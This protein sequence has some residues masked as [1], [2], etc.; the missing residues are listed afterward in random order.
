MLSHFFRLIIARFVNFRFHSVALVLESVMF[1][2]FVVLVLHDQLQS[3]SNDETLIEEFY[4]ENKKHISK[5][6]ILFR[7]LCK[8]PRISKDMLRTRLHTV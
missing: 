8:T 6:K 4:L 7:K 3:L 2:I 5:H 1:G